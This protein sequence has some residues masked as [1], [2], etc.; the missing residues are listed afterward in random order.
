MKHPE[1]IIELQR[2]GRAT[3]F[4]ETRQYATI[5][6]AHQNFK[7]AAQRLLLVNRW[8]EYAGVNS[9]IFSLTNNQG[10]A[11]DGYAQEGALFNINLPVPGS[12]AGDG[13]EWV[14]IERMAAFEGAQAIKEYVAMLV[15]PISDPRKPDSRIAHFYKDVSTSAFIVKRT[16]TTVSA[17]VH[18]RNE[19]P[20]NGNVDLYDKAR[21][22]VVA[23]SARI[24]L[25][26]PQWK[27]LI[28]G[29][30]D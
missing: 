7:K 6:E 29:F 22:T 28:S 27:K 18:G 15:R 3:D 14:M 8:N 13:L 1:E 30:L 16:G 20:N 4:V 17:A 2:T 21:N 9:A 23:L 10:A 25:A 19:S 12:D 11:A 24:G 5:D 26:G